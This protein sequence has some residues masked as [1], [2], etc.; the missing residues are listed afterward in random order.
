V[1]S[2]TAEARPVRKTQARQLTPGVG[3]VSN[4]RNRK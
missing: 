2:E 4:E 3:E 1:R